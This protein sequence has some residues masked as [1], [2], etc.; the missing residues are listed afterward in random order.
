[1]IKEL[2]DKNEVELPVLFNGNTDISV[3]RAQ[4]QVMLEL[5]KTAQTTG[6]I[7]EQIAALQRIQKILEKLLK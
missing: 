5:I 6:D 1:M 4:L 7:N 2:V 3:N